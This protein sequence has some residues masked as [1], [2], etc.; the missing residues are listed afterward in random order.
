MARPQAIVN[1]QDDSQS[2]KTANVLFY[3]YPGCGKTPLIGT[4]ANTLIMDCDGGGSLSARATGSKADKWDVSSYGDLTECYEYLRDAKHTYRWV[5]W[6]SLTL[7]QE[8][9]MIDELVL[10]AHM[11]N[12]QKQDRWVPSQREYFVDHNRIMEF[13]RRFVELPINFGITAHVGTEDQVDDEGEERTMYM[14]QVQGKGMSSKVTGYMNVVGLVRRRAVKV[15][16]KTEPVTRQEVLFQTSGDWFARDRFGKLPSIMANP[17][18]PKIEE[19]L[20]FNS[21]PAVRRPVKAVAKR[22]AK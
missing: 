7:F 8:R 20:G 3:G 6:D 11:R 22:S 13:V 16:G 1:L 12:P 4:G 15:K 10:D 17:T 9:T 2:L 18:I 5:W 19:I 21:R 14:P